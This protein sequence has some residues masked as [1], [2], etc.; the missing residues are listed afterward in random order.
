MMVRARRWFSCSLALLFTL[1][2][3]PLVQAQSKE[4]LQPMELKI[5]PARPTPPILKNRLLPL[6]SKL[7]PGNAVPIYLRL[8]HEREK[9]LAKQFERKPDELRGQ[10]GAK[11]DIKATREFVNQYEGVYKHLHIAANRQKCEWDYPVKES[12]TN[13]FAILLPDAQSMRQY[14]RF[15][16]LKAH[17]EIAEGKF[18]DALETLQTGFAVSKHIGSGPFLINSLVGVACASAMRDEL[19]TFCGTEKAPNIYWALTSLPRPFISLRSAFELEYIGA[20]TAFPEIDLDGK[21]LTAEEWKLKWNSLKMRWNTNWKEFALTGDDAK[22]D[23]AFVE[24]LKL[25]SVDER[26]S[27]VAKAWHKERKGLSDAEIEKL[28]KEQLLLQYTAGYFCEMRDEAF[29]YMYL[30]SQEAKNVKRSTTDIIK[31][32][33]SKEIIPIGSLLLPAIERTITA[34]ERFD[35]K[36]A[37][38]RIV[39]AIRCHAA[40]NNNELPAS[41][42]KI[43]CLPVPTDPV[44]GQAF[45]Y[46]M[47]DGI[48]TL[49]AEDPVNVRN[50]IHYRISIRK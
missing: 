48:A 12:G 14:I 43:S 17:L 5:T 27:P 4:T 3:S 26:G 2:L 35:R 6:E 32:A 23:N 28:P 36:V 7:N 10:N 30:T 29:R 42:D 24:A 46:E 20:L 47:K 44:T 15:I 11:F 13:I 41:L 37:A 33:R 25:I 39:E 16:A 9:P 40:E 1:G 8:E 21:T 45:S 19:E 34:T 18:D 50:G 31:E 49:K 22:N 38:L